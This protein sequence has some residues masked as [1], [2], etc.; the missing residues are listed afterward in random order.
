MRLAYAFL[1]ISV[2]AT[3][4]ALADSPMANA[5]KQFTPGQ[6]V[7]GP[8]PEALPPGAQKAVLYGDP[9]KPGQFAIRL[10]LPKGYR[11]PPHTHPVPEIVTVI[12]G[13]FKLGMGPVADESK[14]TA[15]PAGSFVAVEPGMAH[16]AFFDEDT[17]IQ[18]NTIGPWAVNYVNPKDD[19]RLNKKP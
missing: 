3:T 16:F 15:F 7:W 2:A 19:P 8:G 5:P 1:L 10:K 4:C 6:I 18:T 17:V 11:V 12:S 9:S 13:T 14:T